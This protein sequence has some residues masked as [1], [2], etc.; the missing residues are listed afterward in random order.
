MLVLK[1]CGIGDAASAT[2]DRD[3]LAGSLSGSLTSDMTTPDFNI[4]RLAHLLIQLD[5][6][7]AIARACE[8]EEMRRK[9][10]HDGAD[11]WLRII[12]A[13]GELGEP[14]TAARH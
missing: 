2:R 3:N 1:R 14:P 7:Q 11:K 8:M 10:D 9:G 5:G 13:I 4:Q 6:E 12:V